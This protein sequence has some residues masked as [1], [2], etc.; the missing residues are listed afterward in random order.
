MFGF[1]KKTPT[2]IYR[3][4]YSANAFINLESKKV[5][6]DLDTLEEA[7]IKAFNMFD[8]QKRFV[9]AHMLMLPHMYIHDIKLFDTTINKCLSAHW[10]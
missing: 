2:D 4:R 5:E 3:I 8:A 7:Y 9:N 10:L 6:F 1:F